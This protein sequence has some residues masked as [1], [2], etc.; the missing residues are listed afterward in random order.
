[1][2]QRALDKLRGTHVEDESGSLLSDEE[3]LPPDNLARRKK[4]I[5]IGII[6][7]ICC[8]L[9]AGA[10]IAVILSKNPTRCLPPP[11]L[12][13]T[14]HGGTGKHDVN[15]VMRYT[16]DGC[17][18]GYVLGED[19]AEELNEL[20]G[21]AL[22]PAADGT[23]YL[24]VS[25][26]NKNDS[27][28]VLFGACQPDNNHRE[29]IK[30]LVVSSDSNQGLAH[31]YAIRVHPTPKDA[32]DYANSSLYA[33]NQNTGLITYYNLATGQPRP[34]SSSIAASPGSY[35]PGSFARVGPNSGAS[36]RGFVFDDD[37]SGTVWAADD[38]AY[39]LQFDAM[40]GALKTK[41][42]IDSPIGVDIFPVGD[43]DLLFIG[44]NGKQEVVYAY[45]PTTLKLVMTYSSKKVDH[46]AGFIAYDDVLFVLSQNTQSIVTFNLTTSEFLGVIVENLPDE[47]EQVILSYC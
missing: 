23:D 40:T 3:Q 21:M 34:I 42:P 38:V 7:V 19:D 41:L 16:R 12:Y 22:I 36:F 28:I 5:A 18:L 4:K 10:I 8:L 46:P 15:N 35:P 29:Y 1:M 31:P 6:V 20:R 30:D 33:T 25:N 27:R 14:F 47:P 43:R 37:Q 44:S 2:L 24:L 32:N 39:V 26:A 9:I 17:N 13:V 11:Y 45:D